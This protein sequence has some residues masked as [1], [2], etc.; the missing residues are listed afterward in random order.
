VLLVPGVDVDTDPIT[1]KMV[2]SLYGQDKLTVTFGIE[3][4]GNQEII[5]QILEGTHLTSS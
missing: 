1:R 5:F 4:K 3:Q 2:L